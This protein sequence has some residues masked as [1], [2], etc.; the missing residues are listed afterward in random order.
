M[1]GMSPP[2]LGLLVGLV[3]G[4]SAAFGGLPA[5]LT[6]LA[7]GA[8]GLLAGFLLDGRVDLDGLL[9]RGRST[10]DRR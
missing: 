10:G 3:L 6:V 9:G 5:F 4:V 2:A 7:L 8:L 1:S